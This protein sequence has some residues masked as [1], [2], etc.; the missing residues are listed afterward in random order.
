MSKYFVC[1]RITRYEFVAEVGK[2]R[3]SEDWPSETLNVG[4]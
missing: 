2:R 3:I 1:S 4:G